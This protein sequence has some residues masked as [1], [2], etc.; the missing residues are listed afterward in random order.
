MGTR[1][2]PALSIRTDLL[3][4]VDANSRVTT[5][6]WSLFTRESLI[7][8]STFVDSASAAVDL[9]GAGLTYQL[10]IKD[11]ASP[12]GAF[13]VTTTDISDGWTDLANGKIG[14]TLDANTVE[15]IAYVADSTTLKSLGVE[16]IQLDTAVES[17]I[18]AHTTSRGT[19]DI[20]Q[21]TES[22]P[23]FANTLVH[24]VA[25]VATP[26]VSDDDSEGYAFGSIWLRSLVAFFL[27]DPSTGA[28]L[29]SK[30]VLSTVGV[31]SVT[32]GTDTAM[33]R[34]DGV[35]GAEI[36]ES[37]WLLG[38]DEA[39]EIPEIA[40][41]PAGNPAA[42]A[43]KLYTKAAGL[44]VMDDAGTETGPFGAVGAG[45]VTGPAASTDNMIARHSG[46][47]GKTLQDYTSLPPLVG[48][49][50][51]MTIPGGLDATILGAN[52]PAAID[53]TTMDATGVVSAGAP[54]IPSAIFHGK[55]TTN[56]GTTDVLRLED[57]D[58]NPVTVIDTL[59]NTDLYGGDLDQVAT[60]NLQ[61]HTELT[62][63]AGVVTITQSYHRV[64]TQADA[65]ADDLDT[66][67]GGENGDVLLLRAENVARVVTLA[68]G[69]GNISLP[70][71]DDIVLPFS[72]WLALTNDGTN[73]VPATAAVASTLQPEDLPA[74]VAPVSLDYFLMWDNVANEMVKVD[75]DNMPGGGVGSGD[76]S[77]PAS[78]VD[79]AIARFNGGGG[80]NI[81][82]YSS[83]AP[84]ISDAGVA[85]FNAQVNVAGAVVSSGN[86]FFGTYYRTTSE[87]TLTISGG[88]VTQ[89]R[90][91]QIVD[92]EGAGAA[93]D[94]DTLTP[95]LSGNPFVYLR[96]AAAARVVT[97]KHGTGNFDLPGD[98]DIVLET[99]HFS[100]FWYDGTNWKVVNAPAL[101]TE[102]VWALEVDTTVG[103]DVTTFSVAG[104]DLNAAG[105]YY[106]ELKLNYAV[107]QAGDGDSVLEL[108]ANND[109]VSANYESVW[110]HAAA[111]DDAVF[112]EL[113]D[114][115]NAIMRVWM[116]RDIDGYWWA[117]CNTWTTLAGGV[118]GSSFQITKDNATIVN[119]TRI[120]VLADVALVI[121]TDSEIRI[122]SVAN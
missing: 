108:F 69:A 66:I 77:G 114:D 74:K 80:K 18:L 107:A 34:M 49:N 48:D 122:W 21:G 56:N 121:G 19:S 9:S 41:K 60:L 98:A 97:I 26:T 111:T 14:F 79:N 3:A 110:D 40:V 105:T 13:L 16:I 23:V 59:G 104:L 6:A 103:G 50:G 81:Q 32:G 10:G 20:I 91:F 92:T 46:A 55:G 84:T 57:S 11:P 53:A 82:D 78:S 102:T 47:G 4:W 109:Q 58:G 117:T 35:T 17:Q 64:D 90:T 119:L 61:N 31:G 88:V 42:G 15:F 85:Q 44:F 73:W 65:A 39:A 86:G 38:D 22:A 113:G 71:S 8:R 116:Y 83:A 12:V 120:D 1:T 30:I 43:W 27:Q 99:D 101:A 52:T 89:N 76:V 63:A 96:S 25:D 28:A 67:S 75:F 112:G 45:D 33:V 115:Y 70:N 72:S 2:I 100:P 106:M 87:A 29:W 118:V 94:L 93:D 68:H 7:L 51:N 36:E 54:A 62:I 5:T 24:N 37:T 95:G